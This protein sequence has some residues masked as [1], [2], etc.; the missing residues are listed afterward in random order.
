MSFYSTFIPLQKSDLDANVC[1]KNWKLLPQVHSS[2]IRT[3]IHPMISGCR[4]FEFH[5]IIV[6]KFH[7][8]AMGMLY[9]IM[10]EI[11]NHP[12]SLIFILTW[13]SVNVG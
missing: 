12:F 7:I 6:A 8:W 9:L 2:V 13:K 1:T 10:S 5:T 3:I 11:G 4:N